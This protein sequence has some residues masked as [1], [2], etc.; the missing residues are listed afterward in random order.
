M[1][2]YTAAEL[3]ER[4]KIN[5]VTLRNFLTK[6]GIEKIT[7]PLSSYIYHYEINETVDKLIKDYVKSPQYK[8]YSRSANKGHRT[9]NR[10]KNK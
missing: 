3:V 4:Y 1:T 6:L 2:K 5:R 7:H 9:R 10:K 8:L